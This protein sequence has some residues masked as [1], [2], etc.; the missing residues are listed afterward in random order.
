M[1][2]LARHNCC[3]S[4]TSVEGALMFENSS[5]PSHPTFTRCTKKMLRG[6]LGRSV[7]G[8]ACELLGSQSIDDELVRLGSLVCHKLSALWSSPYL[9]FLVSQGSAPRRRADQIPGSNSYVQPHAEF[10]MRRLSIF[11]FSSEVSSEIRP[12]SLSLTSR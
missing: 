2:G 12:H 8:C 3:A 7:F 9:V 1:A 4:G 5:I 11:G 10:P 6:A